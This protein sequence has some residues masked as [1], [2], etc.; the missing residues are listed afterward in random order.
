MAGDWHGLPE[1]VLAP[2]RGAWRSCSRGLAGVFDHRL[3]GDGAR[4]ER[5][6]FRPSPAARVVDAGI[7][8]GLIDAGR[9]GEANSADYIIADLDRD[10]AADGDDVGQGG[11]LPA[12]GS[13]RVIGF[14]FEMALV[15]LADA[16]MPAG[17]A[18]ACNRPQQDA[19]QG[20]ALAKS[21]RSG[22]SR[23]T[24][25]FPERQRESSVVLMR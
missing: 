13:I 24:G 16:A 20:M 4:L 25:A 5:R 2:Q 9:A 8:A 12:D 11:L 6:L 23:P 1:R 14:A 7:D 19:T 10:A 17:A 18:R 15:A 21:R 22:Y 3:F